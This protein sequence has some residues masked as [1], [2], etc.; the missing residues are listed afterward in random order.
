MT[1]KGKLFDVKRNIQILF[2][3]FLFLFPFS[4]RHLVYE[5]NSY[6]FGNFNPW[7][8]GFVYWPEIL[9]LATFVLWVVSKVK[10]KEI[11]HFKNRLLWALVGLFSANAFAITLFFGDPWMAALFV[12][13]IFEAVILYWLL[14]D[15]ILPPQ[16]TVS[17]L[18]L[19]AFLQIVWGF[20]QWKLNHSLGL[21]HFGESVLGP[22]VL[23]VAK[24]DLANG[25]KQV[26]A[27]G[28]FLHPD[29]F[30]GYLLVILF[31]A[32]HYL[33]KR[34]ALLWIPLFTLGLYFAHSRAAALA[35]AF[36]AG[37]YFLFRSS[38][39]SS[40]RKS[41][42]LA[43]GLALV[44]S[45]AW[46][47]MNPSILKTSDPSLKE[48]LDQIQTSESM[49]LHH[50]LGVG[51]SNFTLEMEKYSYSGPNGGIDSPLA[52]LMPWDF[53]PVH[54]AY[55]LILNETGIQ[56]LLILLAFL[57]ALFWKFWK[58]ANAIPL[59]ILLVLAPF[60]HFLWDSFAGIM[61]VALVAGFFAIENSVSH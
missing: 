59:M 9:L 48:R 45:Q 36:G 50:P 47:F 5:Q 23:G 41:V 25:L 22:N 37:A 20:A 43:L 12:L 4:I 11:L 54:N 26:R 24:I 21:V 61:L 46:L 7:V 28:S 19:A 2:G 58:N 49:F 55:Y 14:T 29:I 15:N 56:G 13:R 42:A 60:D 39:S 40:F 8:S 38:K 35:G 53:Q 16:K 31:I 57:I 17:I 10:N 18:L 34:Q 33:R 27:Y 44:L 52:K 3:L 51:V 1:Q 6:R 30:A 32:L